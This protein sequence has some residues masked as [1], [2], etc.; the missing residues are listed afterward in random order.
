MRLQGIGIVPE[1]PARNIRVGDTLVWN[2]GYT[3]T[4]KAVT[5]SKTGKTLN[6]TIIDDKSGREHI[7]KLR[8]ETPVCIKQQSRR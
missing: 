4:V 7:R 1:Q 6:V 5:P 3:E 2:Y 8:V